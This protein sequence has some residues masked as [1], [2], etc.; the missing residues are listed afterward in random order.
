MEKNCL[1]CGS[2][3]I[4]REVSLLDRYNGIG[5]LNAE[6]R[7]F[8]DPGALIFRDGYRGEVTLDVCGECGH[9]EINVSNH[10]DLYKAYLM[11]QKKK[12]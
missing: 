7:L 9:G 12:R 4:A 2:D 11:S 8:A 1:R 3:N 5:S 10:K 6:A